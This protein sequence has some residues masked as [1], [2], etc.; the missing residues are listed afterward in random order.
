MTSVG[1]PAGRTTAVGA[2]GGRRRQRGWGRAACG[3]AGGEASG[4]G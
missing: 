2:S 4:D 3:E 1:C